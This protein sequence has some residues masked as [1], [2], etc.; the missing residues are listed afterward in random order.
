MSEFVHYALAWLTGLALGGVFFGG[1]WWTVHVFTAGKRSAA[2]LLGSWLLR[3]GIAL[4][5]FYLVGR[6]HWQQLLLCLLGF[7]M[8]RAM[9]QWLTRPPVEQRPPQ[10]AEAKHAP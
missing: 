9:V 10:G 8:A 5:G 3:M 4:T 2:W 7:V 6:E 1:L